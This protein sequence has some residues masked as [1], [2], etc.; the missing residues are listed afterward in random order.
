MDEAVKNQFP[1]TN[2]MIP[3]MKYAMDNGAMIATAGYY[4]AL[5]KDF[6]FQKGDFWVIWPDTIVQ[7]VRAGENTELIVLRAPSVNDKKIIE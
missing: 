1:E 4:H 6:T 3:Q 2:F 5:K 7:N